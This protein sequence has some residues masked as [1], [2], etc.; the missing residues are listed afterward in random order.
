MTRA[1]MAA[2][3]SL[4]ADTLLTG[5]LTALVTFAVP[6]LL[7]GARGA[8]VAASLNAESHVLW[9]DDAALHDDLSLQYTGVGAAT[10]LGACLFW[11]GLYEAAMGDAA[12]TTTAQDY[13]GAAATAA[14]AYVIDYHLVPRRFTPGFEMRYSPGDMIAFFAAL[15]AVLPLRRLVAKR[16]RGAP[17]VV[18]RGARRA[19]TAR[20]FA[21]PLPVAAG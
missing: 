8:P 4:F 12:A 6:A 11:G 17:A 19:P 21:D 5:A 2:P 1:D 13:A 7:R 18:E 20:V 3:R 14:A 10:H 15:V 16:R 9:G